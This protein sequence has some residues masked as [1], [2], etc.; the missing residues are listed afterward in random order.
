MRCCGAAGPDDWSGAKINNPDSAFSEIDIG[1]P[2]KVQT[3]QIPAS[4]CHS[5]LDHTACEAVRQVKLYGTL[6]ENLYSDVSVLFCLFFFQF[7]VEEDQ[8]SVHTLLVTIAV[9]VDQT[10]FSR[11]AQTRPVNIFGH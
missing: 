7:Q 9:Q 8:L 1:I 5:K 4:C 3:Y 2:S 11:S 6:K 10:R